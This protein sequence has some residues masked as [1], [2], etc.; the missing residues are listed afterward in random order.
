MQ[1]G[2]K[3]AKTSLSFFDSYDILKLG[4]ISVQIK[5]IRLFI[6]MISIM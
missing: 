1:A 3:P 5:N 4:M 2:I 6:F